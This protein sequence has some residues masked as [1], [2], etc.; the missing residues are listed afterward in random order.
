MLS[1]S[2]ADMEITIITDITL[3]IPFNILFF[4]VFHNFL[5]YNALEYYL[6]VAP[7]GMAVPDGAFLF[8]ASEIIFDTLWRISS[9]FV[10]ST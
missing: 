6:V 3:V 2:I 7:D 5:C 9:V 10:G 4:I 8:T 1:E